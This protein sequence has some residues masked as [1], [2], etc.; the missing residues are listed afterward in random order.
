MHESIQIALLL[1]IYDDSTNPLSAGSNLT[2]LCCTKI[3]ELSSMTPFNCKD[4]REI[5]DKWF[6]CT[7]KSVWTK[8]SS[9]ESKGR[10]VGC[11]DVEWSS[12]GRWGGGKEGWGCADFGRWGE[13]VTMK[14]TIRWKRLCR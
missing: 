11:V 8:R 9:P 1:V 6:A 3:N 7:E 2:V 10:D 12:M 4:L 5:G 13:A 14:Q